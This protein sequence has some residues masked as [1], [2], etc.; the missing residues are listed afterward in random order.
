MIDD[1]ADDPLARAHHQ[2]ELLQ[3]Q[4]AAVKDELKN[5]NDANAE[6]VRLLTKAGLERSELEKGL[7]GT[8]RALTEAKEELERLRW[9]DQCIGPKL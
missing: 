7:A 8:C 1:P 6:L 5:A 2:I 4:L 3:H 9:K